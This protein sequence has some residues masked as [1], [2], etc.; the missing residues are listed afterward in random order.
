MSVTLEQA[1]ILLHYKMDPIFFQQA[2]D[3]MRSLVHVNKLLHVYIVY[4]VLITDK[5]QG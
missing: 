5:V 3:N 1:H 4:L 2:L